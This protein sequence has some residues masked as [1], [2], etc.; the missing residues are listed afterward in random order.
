MS[1]EQQSASFTGHKVLVVED[2]YFLADDIS[3][4][5]RRA[6]AEVVGPFRDMADGQAALE[7]TVDLSAAV[8]DVNLNGTMV[9]PLAD[10]LLD[11]EVPFVFTTGYD[12]G[13]IPTAYR[14]IRRCEKPIDADAVVRMLAECRSAQ[15]E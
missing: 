8:L 4:A 3:R 14:A 7:Q 10:A 1:R 11:R 13:A 5:L 6:G 15:A 2:E 9:F 12:S